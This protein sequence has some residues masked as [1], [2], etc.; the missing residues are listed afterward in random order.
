MRTSLPPITW[1][2]HS[3]VA[4]R[5]PW[6][7]PILAI[8]CFLVG[9][10]IGHFSAVRDASPHI[11]LTPPGS[12]EQV[13]G[14]PNG[15]SPE[16]L[17]S[18]AGPASAPPAP[19]LKVQSP[20]PVPVIIINPNSTA[21]GR[22]AIPARRPPS[23]TGE[24]VESRTDRDGVRSDSRSARTIPRRER[25]RSSGSLDYSDLRRSLLQE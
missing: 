16:L 24:R 9:V 4:T 21:P 7:A 18:K 17:R 20:E 6:L 12:L 19:L 22:Q 2:S 13:Q 3:P 5:R 10:G 14:H 15:A 25:E 23:W 11:T 1:T 8:S